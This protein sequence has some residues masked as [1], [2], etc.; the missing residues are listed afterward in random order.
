MTIELA[1]PQADTLATQSD[2]F[3]AAI[4]VALCNAIAKVFDIRFTVLIQD[5]DARIDA[6]EEALN[7]ANEVALAAAERMV[8]AKIEEALDELEV[9][10]SATLNTGRR[11]R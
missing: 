10:V 7:D 8:D 4:Q 11:Y 6:L 2:A 9:E 5:Y 1:T 3:S